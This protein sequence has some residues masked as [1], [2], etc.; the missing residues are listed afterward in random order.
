[1][2][3]KTKRQI[4][5][6]AMEPEDLELLYRIENDV[7]LWNVGA[8]N[9]PYSRYALHDYIART[10]ND[11]YADRQLRMMIENENHEVVGIIDLVNFEPRHLRVELG[12]VIINKYRGRGYGSLAVERV[13]KYARDVLHL[14]QLYVFI[15]CNNQESLALFSSI[16]FKKTA[17]LQ[18]WLYLDGSYFD[19]VLMQ[20]LL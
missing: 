3:E 15:G 6:R 1:M 14:H 12:V 13:I 10:Q 18:D 7:H 9:V 4:F 17:Q 19:A 8:T 16:G 2:K 5:L 20:Y 11:I